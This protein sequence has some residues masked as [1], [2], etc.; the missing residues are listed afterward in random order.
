[1]L[2]HVL[3]GYEQYWQIFELLGAYVPV[4][5]EERHLE[6][7]RY[8]ELIHSVQKLFSYRQFK[9][10]ALQLSQCKVCRSAYRPL[11]LI[12]VD[13]HES[14]QLFVELSM[15]PTLQERHCS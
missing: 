2:R 14:T 4:G 7:K 9:Q 11:T 10:F 12:T 5:H 3:H 15:K 8:I 1:M 6:S 13:K